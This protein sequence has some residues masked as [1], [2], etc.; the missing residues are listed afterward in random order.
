MASPRMASTISSRASR[1]AGSDP[2][3]GEAVHQRTIGVVDAREGADGV[4]HLRE[5]A[6]EWI[7]D[8]PV[9]V[10]QRGDLR[11]QRNENRVGDE[12]GDERLIQVP[13]VQGMVSRFM[14]QNVR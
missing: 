1:T 2:R 14:T 12:P 13:L 3:A 5:L 9:V 6:Q 8:G 4:A 7:D 10:V 11:D